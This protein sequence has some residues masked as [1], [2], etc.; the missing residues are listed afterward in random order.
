L[1][2]SAGT[3]YGIYNVS[4]GTITM[5]GNTKGGTDSSSPGIM[6][7][8]ATGV[9]T[10]VGSIDNTGNAPGCGGKITYNPGA[11]N[12]IEYPK[13]TSGTYK[14]GKTIPAASIL[15][16]ATPDGALAPEAGTYHVATAAEVKYGIGFGAASAE[17][18]EYTGPVAADVAAAVWAYASRSLTA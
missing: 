12:Y 11:T 9:F 6:N 8:N 16:S 4:T 14:Y 5:T 15:S 2:G 18:G 7:I 3:T 17:T 1:G 13:P 10:L